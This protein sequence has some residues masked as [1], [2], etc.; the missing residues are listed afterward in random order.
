MLPFAFRPCAKL[1]AEKRSTNH[2]RIGGPSERPLRGSSLL[3]RF[4]LFSDPTPYLDARRVPLNR[5]VYEAYSR[6]WS[7]WEITR[8]AVRNHPKMRTYPGKSLGHH[9]RPSLHRR[10]LSKTILV[11]IGDIPKLTHVLAHS[12][13]QAPGLPHFGG[14]GKT[15]G[16]E[17]SE[18]CDRPYRD[19]SP[20]LGPS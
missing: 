12:P 2:K 13:N 10:P 7:P 9:N 5:T 16:A 18:E 15:P 4:H 6:P 19:F 20:V 3:V 1:R 17:V 14:S 8:E 11:K